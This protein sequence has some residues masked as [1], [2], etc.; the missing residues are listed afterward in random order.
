MCIKKDVASVKQRSQHFYYEVP[1]ML[2]QSKHWKEQLLL[3]YLK[4]VVYYSFLHRYEC[5]TEK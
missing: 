2:A 3:R 1:Y 5:F 4:P